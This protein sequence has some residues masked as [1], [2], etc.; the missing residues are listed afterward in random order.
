M[1]SLIL[2]L[3]TLSVLFIVPKSIPSNPVSCYQDPV[4]ESIPRLPNENLAL[5][6][7]LVVVFVDLNYFLMGYC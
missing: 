6:Q 1:K 2:F 4:V 7:G 5:L 3:F